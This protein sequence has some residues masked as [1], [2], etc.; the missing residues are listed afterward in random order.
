MKRKTILT[1]L[2]TAFILTANGQ[3]GP[4]DSMWES[5]DSISF[6]WDGGIYLPATIDNKYP[7]HILFTTNANRQLV[8]DT[9]YLKEQ[10]WQPPKIEKGLILRET[11]TLRLKASNTK[12][13]VKFGNIAANFPY[14]LITDIRNVLGKHADGIMWETFFEYSPFEVNFQQKF[15]RTLTAIPDS[16][17][18]NYRC[19]PLTVTNSKFMIEAYVWFNNQRIGGLYELCLEGGDDIMFT[20][21]TVRKHNLMAYEG[22]TQ[23][24]LAQYTNIGDTTTTT[25]TFALAD[26]VYLGL[27]N[28]GR[29]AVNISLPTLHAFPQMRNVGYIGA[30]ILH[31]YNLVF[32]PAHNKL[33]YRPY[34]AYTPEKRTWGFSWV[35]RTDIGK[36]W[37]VRSIYKGSAAEKAGIRLGDTILKVNGKKVENYSWEEERVLSNDSTITLLLKTKQGMRKV[38]LKTEPL[39][40]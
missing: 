27:Q 23:Q 40:E 31:N 9:T 11:D 14:M 4:F 17:K 2:F 29:V 20:K 26:S 39:Y 25:T 19:L 30:S 33:Y 5:N 38:T 32:D 16:V 8:V 7:A 34:K 15:L 10:C 35:N 21:E 24:L 13:E 3:R 6:T 22:K 28:I 37:I 36:G 18:R 12:H 1:M